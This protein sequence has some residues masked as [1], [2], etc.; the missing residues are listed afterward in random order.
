MANFEEMR[1]AQYL[2]SKQSLG[3]EAMNPDR[4]QR[5]EALP[6]RSWDLLSDQWQEGFFLVPSLSW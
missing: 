2:V 1:P 6:G 3:E 4:R 5:L